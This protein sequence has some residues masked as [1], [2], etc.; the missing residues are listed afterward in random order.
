MLKSVRI[1]HGCGIV[2]VLTVLSAAAQAA[3]VFADFS[4]D[5]HYDDNIGRAEMPGDILSDEVVSL[6][7]TGNFSHQFGD[8]SGV[9]L[10]GTLE[11]HDFQF[12]D[13]LDHYRFGLGANFRFKPDLGDLAPWY[14]LDAS[15]M[16]SE[17]S[18]SSLRDGYTWD[19]EGT[20]GKR[21]TDRLLLKA[22]FGYSRHTPT[23]TKIVLFP[24]W[25][26]HTFETEN[27]RIFMGLD[28]NYKGSTL[29]AKHS[30]STGD[31]M[32]TSVRHAKIHSVHDDWWVDDAIGP[33]ASGNP[34]WA[35]RIKGDTQLS[36]LGINQV[37]T[38]STALDL[39]LRYVDVAAVNDNQYDNF[40]AHLG[41]F[42]R[43]K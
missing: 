31:V 10:R 27:S 11:H 21:F 19:V 5:S 12:Y 40:S 26:T 24:I 3:E 9:T 14:A 23:N 33:D 37:I 32:S 41:L 38:R 17:Y 39:M 16:A 30:R 13:G 6:K 25:T 15:V 2:L 7:A 34:R 22:G 20:V 28:Y 43:W 18:N 8:T 36:E 42:Y 1:L 29:Y 35:Y 4:L